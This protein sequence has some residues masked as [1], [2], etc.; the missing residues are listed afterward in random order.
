ML[1]LVLIIAFIIK[2]FRIGKSKL[3]SFKENL[4]KINPGLRGI[5]SR[6]TSDIRDF[7]KNTNKILKDINKIDKIINYPPIKTY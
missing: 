4:G 2:V 5:F 7:D 1:Y 6:A 3:E